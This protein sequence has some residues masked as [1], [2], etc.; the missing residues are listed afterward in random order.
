MMTSDVP[1]AGNFLSGG[2]NHKGDRPFRYPGMEPSAGPLCECSFE[3]LRNG[4]LAV[5]LEKP[6]SRS[7]EMRVADNRFVSPFP[8]NPLYLI[9]PEPGI[10]LLVENKQRLVADFGELGAPARTPFHGFVRQD[11]PDNVNP[12]P[13]VDLIPDALQDLAQCRALRISAIHQFRNVFQAHV[14]IFQFFAIQDAH[15]SL[16]APDMSFKR[17][18]HLFNPKALRIRAKFRFSPFS[19]TAKKNYIFLLHARSFPNAAI[20]IDALHAA[21]HPYKHTLV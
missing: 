1:F 11:L 6:R 21:K 12:L 2:M 18:I 15:T 7:C 16:S 9:P 13:V 4:F 20:I 17:E 5:L 8:L 19:A 3:Q 10:A 14:A